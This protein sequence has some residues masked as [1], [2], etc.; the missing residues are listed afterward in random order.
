M[1]ARKLFRSNEA[2]KENGEELYIT[3]GA[4]QLEDPW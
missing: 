2:D 4:E 1:T 3:Y